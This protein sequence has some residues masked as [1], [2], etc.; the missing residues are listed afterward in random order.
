MSIGSIEKIAASTEEQRMVNESLD[1]IEG[2]EVQQ[3]SSVLIMAVVEFVD[4]CAREKY[5][6]AVA[7]GMAEAIVSNFKDKS[8]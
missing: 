7:S 1:V 2:V 3:A 5:R 8:Q 6:Q 4:T